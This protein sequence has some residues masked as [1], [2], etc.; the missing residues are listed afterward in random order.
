M[1]SEASIQYNFTQILLTNEGKTMNIDLRLSV[2]IARNGMLS[3][4]MNAHL[5]YLVIFSIICELL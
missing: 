1:I 4:D 2:K 5:T 3:S